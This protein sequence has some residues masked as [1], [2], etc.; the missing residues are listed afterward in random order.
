MK[1][2]VLHACCAP[3]ASYPIKKLIEDGYKPVV[4]FYNP[5]IYP[6]MEYQIRLNEIREYCIENNMT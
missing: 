5:N 6:L 2:I 1:K 3:C 4:F